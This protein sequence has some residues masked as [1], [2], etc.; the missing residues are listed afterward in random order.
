MNSS[1]T[2]LHLMGMDSTKY[3]GI[4]RFNVELAK[5]LSVKEYHSV[6]VYERWP[7]VEQFA[8]DLQQTGAE[9]VV[10]NSR[11][12]LKFCVGLWKLFRQ[13][14]FS[15]MHAHFTKA[16]FYA[17]PMAV[18]YGMKNIVY[19]FHSRVPTIN[20]MKLHTRLWYRFCNRYCRV[21][22][23]SKQIESVAKANWPN[24]R[25]KNLYLGI[26]QITGDRQQSRAELGIAKNEIM[27]SCIANF[28]HIKGLDIL[29]RAIN[30]LSDEIDL[31]KVSFYIIGQPEKD[32]SELKL[33]ANEL[34][35]ASFI[36]MEGISNNIPMYLC[37]SD[38]YVQPSRSEGIGLGL[39]EAASAHLPLVASR[40]GGIPEVAEE[41]VNAILF[42]SENIESC[43]DALRTL[44]IDTA[45]RKNLADR[46]FSIYQE[47]FTIV[48][49]VTKLIEYYNLDNEIA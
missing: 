42:E 36:H 46:S 1:H 2:I 31:N 8:I 34:G 35:V 27:V 20:E 37:A 43:A 3:G 39:M 28:N 10:L 16:R 33:L 12:P 9:I 41:G 40:V 6:F 24:L 49:N 14:Q 19:T 17:I 26:R 22:T 21:V 23:V 32:I 15:M 13:Y 44:I 30:V 18:L 25:I 7:D 5:Q 29:T 47:K 4:E 48:E 11:N 45:I 38:I